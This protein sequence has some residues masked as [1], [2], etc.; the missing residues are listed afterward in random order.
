MS[1]GL[2]IFDQPK[3]LIPDH[4]KNFFGEESNIADR[5]TVPSLSYEG[6]VWTISVNG[7]RTRLMKRDENGDELP[8]PVM[9][10]VVLDYNKRRGRTYY[11]G[12]YDPGK[13]G[14]PL[15][16]S[17]DGVAPHA[18]AQQPQ[19][20]KCDGCP[21]SV[22]GSKVTEQGKAV[23][24]CSQHRLVAVVPANNLQFTPLRMK[25]AITSDWDKNEENAAQGWFAFAN[26]TDMLRSKGVQHTAALVTKMRF[27]PSVA[28]P[29]VL[30]SPDRWLTDEELAVVRPVVK[31]DAAKSLLT[32]TWSPNG[33]DG[34]R[35][36]QAKFLQDDPP[37]VIAAPK[38]VAAPAVKQAEDWDDDEIRPPVKPVAKAP[39]KAQAISIDMDDDEDDT[40]PPP[41]KAAKVIPKKV[42][43]PVEP[44]PAAA[45]KSVPD[46]L[47]SLLDG[48]DVD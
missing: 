13:P 3:L 2:T 26:Y 19:A 43:Q 27:D 5:Q 30:F 45:T 48:W 39:P 42:D 44:K 9:R 4:A 1:N 40:P 6:K 14:T 16:F 32:G 10:A 8:V 17:E 12:A 15:C 28:F 38:P 18:N 22:K 29:K 47:S 11:A 36:D 34:S 20:S 33:S 24:A 23:A 35:M 41:K 25:L 46:D 7:E 21:M 37:K 31:G